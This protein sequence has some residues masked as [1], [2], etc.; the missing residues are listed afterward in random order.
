[1][2]LEL[3]RQDS[4]HLHLAMMEAL[5]VKRGAQ[6]TPEAAAKAALAEVVAFYL[7][8]P[9]L[10]QIMDAASAAAH[11]IELK[12]GGRT[13][14]IEFDIQSLKE[15]TGLETKEAELVARLCGAMLSDENGT[16]RWKNTDEVVQRLEFPKDLM[17]PD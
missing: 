15:A 5:C 7:D 14:P 1:M 8:S 11:F 4:S 3:N 16:R 12:T 10:G 2:I 6:T 17:E 13:T 9:M